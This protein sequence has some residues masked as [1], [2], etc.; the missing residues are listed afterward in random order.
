MNSYPPE[1]LAQL[2]PIMFVAGLDAFPTPSSSQ[3]STPTS[4]RANDFGLLAARLREALQAQR[5]AA[6]WQPEKTKTFQVILVDR[7][8]RFPPRKLVSQE[9]PQYSAAHSPLSP[10]TP[11]SPLHPDGLIAPIWIRKHT[12][13]VPSV[14]VLFLR[15]FE[16]PPSNSGSPLDAPDSNRERERELEER[17]RDAELAAEVAL[18][19]KTTNERGIK[20]TVVLMATRRMLDDPTL[21]TRLT[22]IRRQSGLDSRAALFVLSPVSPSEL[23]EFVKSLQQALYE[24]AL[25]YYTAH[26]KR[27][28]R[29]RNRH[30]QATSYP[31][32]IQGSSNIARPLR[33]EGWTVRY[34]YKMACFAEFRGE[35]EVALKHYQD[36]HSMLVVMF[37]STAI[38]PPRTKRWAEA[39]VLAD[40]IDVKISK[41]YLYNNEHAL[42]LSHHNTHMRIFSDFSRGW[43]IGEETFEYW[44]WIARQ[45]RILA[46]LLEQGTR[47]TL[48]LPVHKPVS[49]VSNASLSASQNHNSGSR[50]LAAGTLEVD[51]MRSLGINPS[52]A[53]QHPGF[54]YYMAAKCTEMRRERFLTA[55]ELENTQKSVMASPGFMNEKKVDHLT[56]ILELYTKAYELFKKYTI[57]DPQ[58]PTQGRLTLWIA[59]QIAHTYYA[60]AKYDMAIRFFE[61]IAKTYRREKWG[62]LLHPLLS[63]WH[64]CARELGDV[65]LRVKLLIEMLGHDAVEEDAPT[66]YGE[67]LVA[68]LKSTVPSSDEVLIVDISESQ[69]IFDSNVVFWAPEVK[70]GESAAFQ[71]S[72]IAPRNVPVSFLPISSLSIY[73]SH[74]DSP[75]VIRHQDSVAPPSSFQLVNLTNVASSP[76][77]YGDVFAN[78]RWQKGGCFIFAG[79]IS[80][81][82]PTSLKVSRLALT[83][84]EGTWKIEI[85]F[86]PCGFRQGLSPRSRWLSSVDPPR[87]L[88]IEREASSS[89]NVR[90]RSHALTVSLTHESPAYLNETYPVTIDI[91]NIDTRP[92][93]VVVDVLLPPI[94]ID[95]A[96]NTIILGDERSTNFI[97]GVPFGVLAP[98]I[99]AVKTLYLVNTG[100]PGDRVVDISVQ[101]RST[102]AEADSAEPE[103]QDLTET[104]RTL[105]IPTVDPIKVSQTISYTRGLAEWPGLADLNTFDGNI[106]NY[107]R[108]SEALVRT[109]FESAGPSA[110]QDHECAK[111][112]DCS[113]DHTEDSLSDYFPGDE[114]SHIA[115]IV[116]AP[117]DVE[118]G[119]SIT[120]TGSY[121]VNWRRI[122]K[123]GDRGPLATTVVPM[124]ALRPPVEGLLALLSV[125]PAATLHVPISLILTIRNYHPSRSANVVVQLELDASDTFIVAGLRSGRVPILMPGEEE[126]LTWKL[127]PI[128]CGH[129]KIPR[130]KVI[131]RR[132][133]FTG[134]AEPTSEMVTKGELVKIV[135][136]RFDQR[137][138]HTT[139][140]KNDVDLDD[141]ALGTIL[142]LP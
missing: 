46:E 111:I 97:K 84:E 55:L 1:L 129:A 128:E 115:R 106:W 42:A 137:P 64:A 28:R 3:P 87:Y 86:D 125:P 83:I 94:E 58:N 112:V 91:T 105:V 62:P 82:L 131:D 88:P 103:C 100:A 139:G 15:I 34:E 90:H 5:K 57:V 140:T 23:G 121:H 85:P 36:A 135:D 65:E 124:P 40:C 117:S 116:L 45:H 68:I 9:D 134:G 32:P 141:G 31:I 10:L 7:E 75:L 8:V 63:T 114:L 93:D 110:V 27:V 130:I 52:H 126:K 20:L 102:E 22:F 74:R 21:D 49:A 109:T 14:F 51:S 53:L 118:D 123:N 43:G 18:R 56:I 12:S 95:G 122:W 13:L 47:S 76:E 101:S 4:T 41:L 69:P 33:P 72:L 133:V 113:S 108:T 29:K 11:T 142:V 60:S 138:A 48:M 78:L 30:S 89:V 67:D 79:T 26:S 66:S 39:K 119:E 107:S 71:L 99:S 77:E 17:K 24:P 96:A 16:F 37:G 98:G 61:R 6:I 127:I 104:L 73:F 35:D 50:G 44:S 25:E 136:V 70:V 81:E 80:S 59:Y 132:P 2:A 19:K 120:N 54:Y 38:L 92:F